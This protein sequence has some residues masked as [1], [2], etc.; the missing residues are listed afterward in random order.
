MFARGGGSATT[1]PVA[2]WGAALLT[3]ATF[4]L[5]TNAADSTFQQ[6]GDVGGVD[7]DW[8][9]TAVQQQQ[10]TRGRSGLLFA[11]RR[12]LT[13]QY[14]GPAGSRPIAHQAAAGRR[15]I[16]SQANVGAL[17]VEFKTVLT[18]S[19]PLVRTDDPGP[20]TPIRITHPPISGYVTTRA[21]W[22][23]FSSGTWDA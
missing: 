14:T 17:A 19:L 22:I 18:F 23:F 5:L 21:A 4:L 16:I 1:T 12:S 15:T 8:D 3:L 10:P 11:P 9:V 2:R 7:D 6:G 20:R 13:S